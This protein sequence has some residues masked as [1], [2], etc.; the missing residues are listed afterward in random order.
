MKVEVFVLAF[1]YSISAVSTW[2]DYDTYVR[3]FNGYGA[4]SSKVYR[5]NFSIAEYYTVLHLSERMLVLGGRNHIYSLRVSDLTE[6]MP[7]RIHWN[8]SESDFQLCVLK[9]KSVDDC[10]NY[11]RILGKNSNNETIICGT[12]SY[13][14]LCRYYD[15]TMLL[16]QESSGIGMCSYDPTQNNTWLFEDGELYTATTSDFAGRMSII[17]RKPQRT[18]FFNLE[19]LNAANFV[20]SLAFNGYVFFFYREVAV[21]HINC[22]KT[23]YSRVARVCKNDHGGPHRYSD[24]W[25]S[26]LKTRLN[27]SVPGEFPFYFDELQTMSDIV[28][29]QFGFIKTLH[30]VYGVFTTPTNAIGG[31][32]I[33]M[34]DMD[35]IQNSFTGSY[36][37]RQ[38]IDSNWLPMTKNQTGECVRNSSMLSEND[39]VFA[40]THTL[41]DQAVSSRAIFIKVTQNYR[42]S[43]IAIEPQVVTI[44]DDKYDILYIGTDDGRVFKVLT[45]VEDGK[46]PIIVT[47]NVILSNRAPV[48]ELK[49]V[50]NKPGHIIVVG[51]DEVHMVNMKQCGRMYTCGE[52]ISLQDPHCAWNY[53]SSRCETFNYT[54]KSL[55]IQDVRNGD[56]KICNILIRNARLSALTSNSARFGVFNLWLALVF[57]TFI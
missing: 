56:D 19:Q 2:V 28:T 37:H 26:F 11:I 57:S 9:G 52:C 23:I 16:K 1:F 34:F 38:N 25:T 32:A 35:Q 18:E 7:R 33:C 12:N 49:F 29:I 5:R 10:Q 51:R 46:H 27:C 22:G 43:T 31:S 13:K 45:A 8:S 15:E 30:I 21:E 3:N 53:Y 6:Y 36:K 24:K 17:Y 42:F 54:T 40:L 4:I 48:K 20:A 50:P 44:I 55:F 39:V 14:P 41:M 47:E